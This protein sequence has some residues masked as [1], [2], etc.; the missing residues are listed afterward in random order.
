MSIAP[1]PDE[2][3]KRAAQEGERRLDQSLL[4]L[5]S[6]GFIAGFTIVFGTVALGV[7]QAVFTASHGPVAQIAGALAFPIGLVFLVV[8]RAELFSENFFDPIAAAVER[9]R[10]GAVRL[11]VRLWGITWLLNLLGG[12]VFAFILSV[13]GV[14]PE[15]SPEVLRRTAQ[16]IVGAGAWIGFVKAVAGGAL[17]ALLSFLLKAVDSIGSRIAMAYMTGFL[18]SIGPFEHV[19]V[20]AL[21]IIQAM[22]LGAAIAWTSLLELLAVVTLGNLLGGLGLVTLTHIAQA[23]G[24]ESS[25]G[26]KPQ[27]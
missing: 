8:G 13:D 19:I 4:E 7:V 15:G 2:I 26:D 20:T 10:S 14:L 17:V 12:A 9:R 24:E 25:N 22:L 18:L 5:V 11:I 21:Y 23:I 1:T 16:D 27:T 3:Y 6:N